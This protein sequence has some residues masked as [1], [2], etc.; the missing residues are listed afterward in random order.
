MAQPLGERLN[1]AGQLM[2][3]GLGL[4]GKLQLGG[5]PVVGTPRAGAAHLGLPRLAPRCSALVEARPR[6]GEAFA[7]A[8]DVKHIAMAQRVA[9]CSLLPGAQAVS[10]IG[11]RMVRIEPL[12]GRV[13]QVH[14]PGVG[15]A[16]VLRSQQV[17]IGRR[18]IDTGQHGRG[19]LED[20]V[21]QAHANA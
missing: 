11:D 17:A 7:L 1:I 5:E 19:T 3:L 8:L 20:L 18:G 6:V 13:E 16:V 4:P 2:R 21:M 10:C 14:A 15:V 9:P 12:L